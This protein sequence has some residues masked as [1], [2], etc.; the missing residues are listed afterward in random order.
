MTTT[1]DNFSDCFLF[2]IFHLEKVSC[3][4]VSATCL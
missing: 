4:C 2:K 3:W 1:G